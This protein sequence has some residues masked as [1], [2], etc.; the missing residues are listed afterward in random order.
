MF[1]VT[2][3]ARELSEIIITNPSQQSHILNKPEQLQDGALIAI[4]STDFRFWLRPWE[5]CHTPLLLI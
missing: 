4:A 5:P 1:S 3:Q 2:L